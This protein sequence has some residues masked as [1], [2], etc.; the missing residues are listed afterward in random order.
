MP[1]ALNKSLGLNDDIIKAHNEGDNWKLISLYT[2]ASNSANSTDLESFFLTQA[3]VLALEQNH[4]AQ[5]QLKSRLV[6][7]GRE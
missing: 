2:Q 5:R 3:Y 4:P 1:T 7:F 6:A